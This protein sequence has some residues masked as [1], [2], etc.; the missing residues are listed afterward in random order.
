MARPRKALATPT[1]KPRPVARYDGWQNVLTG[2][3]T[4]RDKGTFAS[5]SPTLLSQQE[6]E[7]LWRGDPMADVIVTA[8]A[9]DG[10][11][12]T[13]TLTIASIEDAE[14]RAEAVDLITAA[15]SDL[16]VKEA[17][18]KA[19]HYERAYGGSAIYVGAVDGAIDAVQPLQVGSIRAIRHL[20][21]FERR[22]LTA[23]Q[24]QED[25]LAPDYG[26]PWLYQVQSFS[27]IGTGQ[28]VHASRLVIFPGRR[29]TDRNPTANDGWGDSVLALVWDVLRIF[30]MSFL[31]VGYTMNDLSVAIMKIKGLAAIVAAN[32]PEA[33]ATRAQAIELSRSIAKTIL[34]DSEEE[35][36]RKTTS[37]AGVPEVLAE[38]SKLLAA[39]AQ[40]PLSKLFGQSAT[41]LNATGEGDA[42]NWYD[43]VAA[44][45][46]ERVR[47]AYEQLLKLLFASKS[48]PTRGIEP[49]NWALKFPA[50][51]QP[52]AKEQAE[53]RKVVAETDQINYDMGLVTSEELRSSR[54]GGEEYSAETEV[55]SAPDLSESLALASSGTAAAAPAGTDQSKAEPQN[56]ALQT[57]SVELTP[58]DLATIIT[59]NEKRAE[60]GLPPWPDGNVSI[61]EFQARNAAVI[62]KAQEATDPSGAAPTT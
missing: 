4:S 60:F 50:L 59:V 44:Y 54:F 12:E 6:C 20:T 61:A 52:T 35:Y 31:G 25:P 19:L 7:D 9:N 56:V 40:M 34:L 27:G 30:N 48:G 32:S 1:P 57:R 16:G 15:L 11:R 43:A 41:G 45:Q 33:V 49:A 14:K 53:T 51:W 62:A 47:P 5:I 29:V 28:Q 26:K 46:T 37:L 2:L 17:V 8:L 39:A 13:P 21:V 55:D 42:R 58:T 22:Q 23:V 18:R 10:L 24:Y 3:G 38:V 36:E